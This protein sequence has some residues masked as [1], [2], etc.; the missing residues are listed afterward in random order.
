MQ[1]KLKQ[2]LAK[3]LD[4]DHIEE[5]LILKQAKEYINTAFHKNWVEFYQPIHDPIKYFSK[6]LSKFVKKILLSV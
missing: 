1:V 2:Y 5:E 4:E 3:L 6:L